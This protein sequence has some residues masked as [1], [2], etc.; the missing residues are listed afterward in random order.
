VCAVCK[1]WCVSPFCSIHFCH[2][3]GILL[4]MQ[5]TRTRTRNKKDEMEAF[6]YFV[7]IVL[8]MKSFVWSWGRGKWMEKLG[9]TWFYITYPN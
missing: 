7:I 3:G 1:M 8:F 6:V 5:N 2:D 4:L 9:L